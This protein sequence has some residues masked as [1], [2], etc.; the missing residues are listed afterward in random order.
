MT[1]TV[2]AITHLLWCTVRSNRDGRCWSVSHVADTVDSRPWPS[3]SHQ[4][5]GAD[6]ER[7]IRLVERSVCCFNSSHT[8]LCGGHHF[9]VLWGRVTY[10]AFCLCVNYCSMS[11]TL[12]RFQ[13]EELIFVILCPDKN[14]CGAILTG[15]DARLGQPSVCLS[16]RRSLSRIQ[17]PNWKLKGVEKWKRLWTFAVAGVTGAPIVTLKCQNWRLGLVDGRPHSISAL[18]WAIFLFIVNFFAILLSW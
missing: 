5:S 3:R 2:T 16:D 7:R 13:F 4:H 18:G 9:Y 6:Q 15:Q 12:P 17:A 1:V 11:I 8:S 14:Y 10:V